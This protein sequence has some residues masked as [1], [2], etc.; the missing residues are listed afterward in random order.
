[1]SYGSPGEGLEGFEREM[2]SA[3]PMNF[4]NKQEILL[5]PEES[6]HGLGIWKPFK[7]VGLLLDEN[8]AMDVVT[9]KD[10]F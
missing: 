1:M 5:W 8:E 6:D 10:F 9:R 7:P 4:G 3:V 2:Y